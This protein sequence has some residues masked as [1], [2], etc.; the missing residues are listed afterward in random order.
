VDFGHKFVVKS[1][2]DMAGSGPVHKKKQVLFVH[3][4]G[5][6]GLH[7]GSNDLVAWLRLALGPPYE[8]LYPLMP[9]PDQPVYE[10]WKQELKKELARLDEGIILIGHSLGGSV[11]LKLLSEEKFTKKIDGIFMIGSP[12]WGKRNWKV[13]EYELKHD[14]PVCLPDVG[15]M[16][17]YHSRKDA[18]VPFKHLSYYAEKLP[19]ANVRALGGSEH[20]FS[21][22]LPELARDIKSLNAIH[23]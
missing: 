11:I 18:V 1:V 21:S 3:S 4:G 2:S 20:I 12:Y 15:E 17:L 22:G 9:N 8:V 16:Y 19:F 14:F 23:N 5:S 10:Q 6:Q 13:N 7:E